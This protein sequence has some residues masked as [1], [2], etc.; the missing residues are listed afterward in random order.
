M[1]RDK[2]SAMSYQTSPHGKKIPGFAGFGETVIC[3]TGILFANV[4]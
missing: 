3:F 4:F 1:V 2:V